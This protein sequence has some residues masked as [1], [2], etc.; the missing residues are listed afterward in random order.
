MNTC[1]CVG[2]AGKGEAWVP[3]RKELSGVGGCGGMG[4]D[5]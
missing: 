5:L 1:V 2:A 3:P 4:N